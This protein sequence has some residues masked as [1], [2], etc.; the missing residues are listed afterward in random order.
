MRLKPDHANAHYVLGVALAG[1]GRPE[2]AITQYKQTLAL[3]PNDAQAWQQLAAAFA[4][5]GR[6]AEALA[7]A[8]QAHTRAQA[9]GNNALVQ[10]SEA[11][12]E[13]YRAATTAPTSSPDAER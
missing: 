9:A 4:A 11:R 5:T 12:I 8:E 10:Q 6:V 2:E 1:L 13:E 7:A 3:Q